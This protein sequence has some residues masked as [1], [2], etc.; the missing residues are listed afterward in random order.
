MVRFLTMDQTVFPVN[1]E[2][3]RCQPSLME[4][5]KIN[6]YNI[7]ADCDKRRILIPK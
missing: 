2:S 6:E 4:K 5:K 3:K 7:A 1:E